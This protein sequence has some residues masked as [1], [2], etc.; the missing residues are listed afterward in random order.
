MKRTNPIPFT[1]R[2]LVAL[3]SATLLGQGAVA[4][5]NLP[6]LGDSVSADVSIGAEKKLGDQVMRQIRPDPDYIDDPLPCT[7]RRR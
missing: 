1:R 6:A 7:C 3:L 5:V 4:Q 2:C